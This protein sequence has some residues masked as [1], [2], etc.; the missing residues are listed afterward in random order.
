MLR[1]Q[2][3]CS[4][5]SLLFLV[6]CP[7]AEKA[8]TAMA[9]ASSL[10]HVVDEAGNPLVAEITALDEAGHPIEPMCAGSDPAA[11]TDWIVGF[12]V[13]GRINISAA[14]FDGCNYGSGSVGV[15]VAMDEDGCHVVQEEAT[16]EVDEWTDLDCT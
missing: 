2:S 14:A 9:A 1:C 7:G 8:C 16:L 11:C 5:L 6:A 4:L 12:E 3:L 15:D 13:E 10:I